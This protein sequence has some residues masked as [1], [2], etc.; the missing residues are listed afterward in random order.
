MATPLFLFLPAAVAV[1]KRV[2]PIRIDRRFSLSRGERAGVRGNGASNCIVRV[3][4]RAGERTPG[5]MFPLCAHERHDGRFFS[6]SSSGAADE[7]SVRNK[8]NCGWGEEALSVKVGSRFMERRRNM[9]NTLIK[10][11][12]RPRSESALQ[13]V[14][15]RA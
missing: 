6:L 13:D 9:R 14:D 10:I 5:T 7:V 8:S 2:R 15:S 12:M 3:E 11:Q 1:T 4:E